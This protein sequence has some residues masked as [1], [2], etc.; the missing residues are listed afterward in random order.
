M[1]SISIEE[2]EGKRKKKGNMVF[3]Q[4][5]S[6]KA[7]GGWTTMAYKDHNLRSSGIEGKQNFPMANQG[8][9]TFSS[10]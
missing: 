3:L 4:F 7:H 8:S 6:Q 10:K 1:A 5:I 9:G 2:E